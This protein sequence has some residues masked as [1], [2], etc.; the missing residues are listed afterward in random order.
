MSQKKGPKGY[1]PITAGTGEV[2]RAKE[3]QMSRYWPLGPIPSERLPWAA[4]RKAGK[5]PEQISDELY[6]EG[7]YYSEKSVRIRLISQGANL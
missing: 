7:L 4:R 3:A 2:L 1:N 5:S 6:A